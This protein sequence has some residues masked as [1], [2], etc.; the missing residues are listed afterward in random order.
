MKP[1]GTDPQFHLVL[2]VGL[3]RH[4]YIYIYTQYDCTLQS[5]TEYIHDSGTFINTNVIGNMH[6]QIYRLMYMHI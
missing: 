4:I 1:L 6:I 2:V 3:S 5:C